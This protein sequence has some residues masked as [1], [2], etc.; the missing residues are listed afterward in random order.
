M[1]KTKE[2]LQ[3][4][5]S[6]ESQANRRY[7]AFAKKAEHEGKSGIAKIFR[8]A[9]EGET[10]H[11]LNHFRAMGAVHGTAENLKEAIAGETYEAET[12]YPNFLEDAKREDEKG[13]IVSFSGALA[14]E[15]VHKKLFEE[16]LAKE[17][18]GEEVAPAD[19]YVCSVCGYPASPEAPDECPVCGAKKELFRR[20][21]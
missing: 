7:L 18:A 6:G 8:V 14:V 11:A 20:V 2:D 17:E 10:V 21:E 4:A 1:N 16:A 9:A 15:R 19:F 3:A 13:A 5:F 12:M